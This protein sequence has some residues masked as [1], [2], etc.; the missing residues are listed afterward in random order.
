MVRFGKSPRIG[1]RLNL[2]AQGLAVSFGKSGGFE[3]PFRPHSGE[4]HSIKKSPEC[5][6]TGHLEYGVCSRRG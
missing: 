5:V 3:S 2:S 4:I 1:L 6:C